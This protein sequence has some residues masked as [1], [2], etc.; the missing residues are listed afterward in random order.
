[1]G[2]EF[3]G[4]G[5]NENGPAIYFSGSSFYM[6]ASDVTLYAIW[7]VA[8]YT[9]TYELNGGT[10]PDA[11]VYKYTY[12]QVVT[13]LTTNPTRNGY[14]FAGWGDNPDHPT[15][16]YFAS[17]SFNM[18]S[19]DVTLYAIWEYSYTVVFNPNGGTGGPSALTHASSEPSH[20][21]EL[22]DDNQIRDVHVCVGWSKDPN[23][24]TPT[25]T[26]DSA[27]P[28]TWSGENL[29]RLELYAVWERSFCLLVK[30]N[31]KWER[32]VFYTDGEVVN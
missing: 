2:Y 22:P 17:D 32:L 14:S 21:F 13:I 28:I 10:I 29:G 9:L 8:S 15:T 16:I 30:R 19:K 20:T 24:L 4:W 12:N 26:K 11:V 1:M 31:G 5:T 18:P 23:A 3:V 7:S 25:Y 6:G 27:I